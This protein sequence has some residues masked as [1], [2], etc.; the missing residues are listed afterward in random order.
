[1]VY[2]GQYPSPQNCTEEGR[3]RSNELTAMEPSVV[4]S[5][6]FNFNNG[7]IYETTTCRQRSKKIAFK[8]KA[9]S[10]LTA[11]PVSSLAD[12]LWKSFCRRL[13]KTTELNE[14]KFR[15]G[16]KEMKVNFRFPFYASNRIDS[17][18][19]TRTWIEGSV[20]EFHH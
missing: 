13:I 3:G 8:L 2:K 12:P 7:T 6:V 10:S 5:P 9:Q 4:I 14:Q 19:L 11:T 18:T 15:W 16:R 17:F 1:M 20:S